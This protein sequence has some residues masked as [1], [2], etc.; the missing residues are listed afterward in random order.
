[1]NLILN[2]KREERLNKISNKENDSSF[3]EVSEETSSINKKNYFKAKNNNQTD[4]QSFIPKKLEPPKLSAKTLEIMQNLKEERK[5]RFDR[6][7]NNYN[8]FRN[9]TSLSDI[10]Y[11]YEE[12]ITKPRELR[13]PVKYKNLYQTFLSLEQTICLNKIREKNQLNTFDNIRNSVENVTKHSFN[14][15]TLQQILYIVPH[16][17]ILKYIEKKK[18]ST[19]N[20]NDVL[21]KDYDLLIDIPKDYEERISKNYPENFE[22][23]SINYYDTKSDEFCPC[24]KPLNLKE[25]MKRKD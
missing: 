15:K 14:M 25:S 11:K 8:K 23:L 7:D 22:F 5:N 6:P 18:D 17:Y 16:F 9:N 21:N 19:F 10:K 13:L 1:M 3:M 4:S 12:L 2:K 20:M 24:D